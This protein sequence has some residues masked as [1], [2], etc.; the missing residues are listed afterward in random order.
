MAF[1]S[2]NGKPGE[3]LL[4]NNDYSGDNF[5]TAVT[6][7]NVTNQA[8][9]DTRGAGRTDTST[10]SSPPEGATGMSM[11]EQIPQSIGIVTR[12]LT[13]KTLVRLD[14]FF[15]PGPPIDFRVYKTEVLR[16]FRITFT[17]VNAKYRTVCVS[18]ALE[19]RT[20]SLS[21]LILKTAAMLETHTGICSPKQYSQALF[22]EWQ[23]W[24]AAL[25][26]AC[27]LWLTQTIRFKGM[28]ILTVCFV[29]YA[30]RL[31]K[32]PESLVVH[33]REHSPECWELPDWEEPTDF[34]EALFE[35]T[36]RLA[37]TQRRRAP[38]NE[39]LLIP[40]ITTTGREPLAELQFA[41]KGAYG[42]RVR[43]SAQSL[44]HYPRL[45]NPWLQ[46]PEKH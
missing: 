43:L 46:P 23:S 29:R 16:D 17:I 36:R 42:E 24:K 13:E 6:M 15:F 14:P 28:P 2:V 26:K 11:Q 22:S 30:R 20:R 9:S 25:E 8:P 19:A 3:S 31:L 35:E 27:K 18:D 40:E 44:A 39:D 34:V 37:P 1:V 41:P 7:D 4:V 5:V 33:I 45:D 12:I 38:K 21:V 10:S 32:L